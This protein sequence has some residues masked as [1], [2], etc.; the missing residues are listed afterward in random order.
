MSRL[1][2]TIQLDVKLQARNQ[3]YGIGL[4]L[5]VLLGLIV[6]FF[7]PEAHIGRSLVAYYVLAL[8]GTTF[9]FG[10]AMLLLEKGEHT[11][12]ALRTSMITTQDYVTSKALTLTGFAMAE[13]LVLY[14]LSAQGV[15]TNYVWL[16]VGIA[17]LGV[18]YTMMGLAF[19]TPYDSVTA[20][21]LPV[22]A[23][24]AMVLQLPFL[25]LLG[26][27]PWWVWY[28]IPTQAPLLILL[29]AFEPLEMW[30]WGYV[31]VMSPLMLVGAWTFCRQ[32]FRHHIQF[33]EA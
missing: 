15:P 6:R 22:G 27:S 1:S 24:V 28:L 10:A 13:S 32:R 11:L 18:F 12:E 30:Q 7:V 21:M 33:P 5:A 29:A 9:M 8:G 26:V 25:S 16:V 19:A 14:A 20:F 31:A 23:G 17:L 3:L 4:T 2:A